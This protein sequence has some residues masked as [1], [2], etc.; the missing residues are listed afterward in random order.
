M[1]TTTFGVVLNSAHCRCLSA[2]AAA[3]AAAFLTAAATFCTAAVAAFL[4]AAAVGATGA[5]TAG[6]AT[7]SLGAVAARLGHLFEECWVLPHPRQFFVFESLRDICF[8]EAQGGVF[9]FK[10]RSVAQLMAPTHFSE[11]HHCHCI[12]RPLLYAQC[13]AMYGQV[14]HCARGCV[15]VVARCRTLPPDASR[16]AQVAHTICHSSA[17]GAW[18]CRASPHDAA[19]RRPMQH[20]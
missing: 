17:V 10:K 5:A 4:T 11:A 8:F 16:C 9:F 12:I 18:L 6:A 15:P 20:G 13:T 7:A 3:V 1:R 2:C 14:R 19:R